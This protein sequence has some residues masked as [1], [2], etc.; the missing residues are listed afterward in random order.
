MKLVL[1]KLHFAYFSNLAHYGFGADRMPLLVN[2]DYGVLVN[3]GLVRCCVSVVQCLFTRHAFH[4]L[5][6]MAW[7]Y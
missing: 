1:S 6:R 7:S 5:L 3:D 2:H 4:I